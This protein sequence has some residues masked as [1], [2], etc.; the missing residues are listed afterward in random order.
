MR[1]FILAMIVILITTGCGLEGQ[2][3]AVENSVKQTQY[4]VAD[5]KGNILIFNEKPKRI[6]A[7][8]L[9]LEE[10]LIDLVPLEHITAISE[11]AVDTKISLIANKAAHIPVKLP[12]KVS[13]EQILSLK[14]DLIIVQENSNAAFIQALKDVGLKVYIT[15]VPT[16]L[17]MVRQRIINLAE[18]VGEKEQGEKIINELD[19]KTEFVKNV[20]NKIPS[21]DK[22]VLIAYSLLGVFGSAEGLFND[23]C[24]N[25]G[26]I[27]GAALAGLVRG[28]HL[29]KEKIID[30]DPDVLMFSDFSST[31]EG[32][33][34]L[35]RKEVL[36]D[37]A[38]QSIKAIKN[39]NVIIIKDR[40]RYAAS[41]Y[42]GDGILDIAQKT[43]PE[44]FGKNAR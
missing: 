22:K 36:T 30:V 38:L 21:K 25:S 14:P 2:G 12:Q 40:H 8:T 15:K 23:I 3:T 16:T 35:F 34:E 19:A 20:M 11:P 32:D 1:S 4:Q 26:V 33:T 6:Y 5:D 44:A 9:S 18:A 42:I 31:Q 29:S 27:N 13:V 41:Q 24:I 10:I 7:T 37:P 39:N 28:E 17:K 43:Y